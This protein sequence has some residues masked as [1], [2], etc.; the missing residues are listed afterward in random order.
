[1]QN[2]IIKMLDSLDY[3]VIR[4]DLVFYG[5]LTKKEISRKK[6]RFLSDEEINLLKRI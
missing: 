1:M 4:L 3:H 5:G 6:Y 2:I